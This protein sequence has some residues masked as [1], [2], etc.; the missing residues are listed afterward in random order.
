[1]IAICMDGFPSQPGLVRL[2]VLGPGWSPAAPEGTADAEA[3]VATRVDES[4]TVSSGLTLKRMEP[5]V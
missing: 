3:V 5:N 2:A 4:G 1:M